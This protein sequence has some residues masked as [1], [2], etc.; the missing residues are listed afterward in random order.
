MRTAWKQRSFA[1]LVAASLLVLGGQAARAQ[2]WNLSIG[3]GYG[4]YYGRPPSVGF[5]AGT[6][7]GVGVYGAPYG[8][9]RPPI[10]PPAVYLPPPYYAH[11]YGYR[12]QFYGPGY[13]R[14]PGCGPRRYG[15]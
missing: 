15:W 5:Y 9:L 8:A 11:R 12:P 13:G 10:G 3:S 7:P 1:V 14:G 6:V 4:G 2:G